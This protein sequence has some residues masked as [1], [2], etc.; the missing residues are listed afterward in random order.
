[1]NE[2]NKCAGLARRCVSI[3]HPHLA[4]GTSITENSETKSIS[5]KN[6]ATPQQKVKRGSDE[7]ES[8]KKTRYS[9]VPTEKR[10]KTEPYDPDEP[11]PK[12]KDMTNSRDSVS[13]DGTI[14]VPEP[15]LEPNQS[16][17]ESLSAATSL[18]SIEPPES[19]E[20]V[21]PPTVC[22]V[23]LESG[24]A[25]RS[26]SRFIQHIFKE[27][28]PIDFKFD[29]GSLVIIG[30]QVM[31]SRI[32]KKFHIMR[33]LA[34]NVGCGLDCHFRLVGSRFLLLMLVRGVP[35]VVFGSSITV[36]PDLT[37]M[38]KLATP[39]DL[40][41]YGQRAFFESILR[42][43]PQSIKNGKNYL[44]ADFIKGDEKPRMQKFYEF[45]RTIRGHVL[46]HIASIP[47]VWTTNDWSEE[48]DESVDMEHVTNVIQMCGDYQLM[49]LEIEQP[50][51]SDRWREEWGLIKTKTFQQLM[52]QKFNSL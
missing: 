33:R 30:D 14:P 28:N 10:R 16:N 3:A 21:V 32:E 19:E 25:N 7:I 6:T 17:Q 35:R 27:V 50:G 36:V 15:E 40:V 39:G 42:I 34:H 26:S 18:S 12:L 2:R 1:M 49:T 8:S 48:I 38:R 47:A 45:L 22:P 51:Y 29:G 41:E 24:A 9:S 20:A 5:A 4:R 37:D 52:D 11:M 43:F 46:T 13:T 31:A 23:K 44:T